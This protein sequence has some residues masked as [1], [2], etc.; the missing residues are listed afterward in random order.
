M[1]PPHGDEPD[2]AALVAGARGGDA[3]ALDQLCRRC[4]DDVLWHFTAWLPAQAEDLTQKLFAGLA[5]KLDGYEESG[6]FRAWL[7]GVAYN[8]Y[9][10][11]RRSEHRRLE[12]TLRT[13]FDVEE[14][15]SSTMF[16]TAKK[17]LRE[18]A[19]KLPPALRAVWELHI[20]GFSHEEIAEKLGI[21]VGA[22]YTR[23]HRARSLLISW[24]STSAPPM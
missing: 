9:R 5:R 6:R 3:A 1:T 8:M 2:L 7:R 19:H 15:E 20:Q 12:E 22:V 10:T 21:G 16:S 17:R 11:Q 18:L 14:S 23:L 24:M 13:A 4:Y